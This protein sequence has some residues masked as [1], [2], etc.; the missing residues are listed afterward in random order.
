V[1]VVLLALVVAVLVVLVLDQAELAIQ[2]VGVAED[3]VL[4]VAL[5]VLVL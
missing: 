2:A 3:M 1:L 5:A 4:L